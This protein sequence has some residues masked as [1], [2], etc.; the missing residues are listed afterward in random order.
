MNSLFLRRRVLPL[1]C[2]FFGGFL[3]LVAALLTQTAGATTG[4]DTWLG[5]TGANW[6]AA[7]N[8]TSTSANKPPIG[9]DSLFFGVAGSAGGSLNNDVTASTAFNGVTF[10]PGAGAFTFSGNPINLAGNVS[11]EAVNTETINLPM[12]MTATRTCIVTNGGNLVL[13]G[14]ISGSG[15]GITINKTT[16]V[17]N[18]TTPFN[19][20]TLTLNG[21]A[22][23]TYTGPTVVN[24]GTLLL[25][26]ANLAT[27]VNLINSG[28]ALNLGGL[29]GGTLYVKGQAGA[30]STAQTFGNFGISKNSGAGIVLN[31]NGGAG[32]TLTLGNTWS[33][34]G[35]ANALN[36]DL[37][38]GGTLAS[39]PTSIAVNNV[40]GFAT[41]KDATGVG[42]ATLTNGNIVRLTGQASLPTSGSSGTTDYVTSGDVT[43]SPAGFPVNSLTLDASS[44][45]GVLDLGGPTDVLFISSLGLLMTGAN[46]FIITNGQVG[47]ANVE[48]IVHQMGTGTLTIDG[49]VGSG[50]T[51][52]LTKNGPGTLLLNNTNGCSYICINQ[53]TVKQGV[54]D[55]VGATN[56][57][58]TVNYGGIMDLNGYNLDVGLVANSG[59][60][61]GI[62]TNS[63]ALANFT[64]GNGNQAPDLANTLVCGRI[65]LIVNGSGSAGLSPANTHSGGTTF[66]N[67]SG[68]A[69]NYRINVASELGTGPLGFN[70]GGTLQNSAS[71]AVTN[72]IVVNGSGNTW[73]LDSVIDTS[74]GPW[75][76]T[77]TINILQDAGKAPTFNFD[78]NMSG[79]QGVLQLTSNTNTSGAGLVFTYALGGAG[80][81]DGSHAT[82]DLYSTSGTFSSAPLLEWAGTGSQTIR[83][84]DLTSAGTTGNGATIVSNSVGGS[85]A[86]FEVGNLGN[87]STF[88]GALVKGAGSIA[89]TKVGAG[90]WT[91]SG[92]NTY[93]GN[94]TVAVGTLALTAPAGA[95]STISNSSSITIAGGAVLNVSGM[96]TTFLLGTNQT[97]ASSSAGGTVNGNLDAS[98]GAVTVNYAANPGLFITNG[99]LTLSTGTVFNINNTGAA[100]SAGSYK[101]ISKAAAGNAGAVT[102]NVPT[103]TV[104]GAGLA[105]GATA[106]LQIT[107]G[108]LYLIVSGG[109]APSQPHITSFSLNGTVLTLVATNGSAA[110]R[111]VLL[112]STNMTAPLAQWTP[113]LTNVFDGG[114]MLNL[115]TNVVNPLAPQ[116]FYILSQ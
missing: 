72:A 9:G 74:T 71:F 75:A 13:G 7:A 56:M 78:G 67:N 79:F 111:Y 10:N 22:V 98:Q 96:G 106:S 102:G 105:P 36:I 107:S 66:E 6:S 97:L 85:T 19:T 18:V 17:G 104:G 26:F 88:S 80:T 12:A 43:T 51:S 60:G 8:W 35:G 108:E 110:A 2:P 93:T 53:G 47:A 55:A 65:N 83:L 52:G 41:V 64:V 14:A 30:A 1:K 58:F 57:S 11:D 42:L 92:T 48:L 115:S 95:S 89:L 29:G 94:T 46:D 38:A 61:P 3:A 37:S 54:A 23:N 73:W 45:P 113:V 28:S 116:E 76:G 81:F 70:G 40:L 21:S 103:V 86:T 50:T 63:G 32:T 34:N 87:N 44:G 24:G 33:R 90:I 82:W 91:L 39:T 27:P 59:A 5:N 69:S 100:L 84:G 31:P 112:E 101:I 68:P 77:G 4:N 109:S 16:A 114:G 20:G 25:D 49:T 15:F 62:V 99:N